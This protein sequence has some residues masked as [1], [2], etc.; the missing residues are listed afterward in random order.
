MGTIETIDGTTWAMAIEGESK[1]VDVSGADIEGEPAVGLEAEVGAT[2]V[3]NSILA[4]KVEIR[5]AGT[6]GS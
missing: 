3:G 5:E 1:M 6:G 4:S 2:V